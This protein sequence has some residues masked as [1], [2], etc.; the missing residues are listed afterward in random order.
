MRRKSRRLVLVG[1]A[2]GVVA[3]AATLVLVALRDSVVFFYGPSERGFGWAVLSNR[4]RSSTSARI[5]SPS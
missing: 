5:R 3:V 1:G 2:L 4:G